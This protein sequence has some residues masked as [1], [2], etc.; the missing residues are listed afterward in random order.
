MTSDVAVPAPATAAAN[1]RG[2]AHTTV[3]FGALT[4]GSIG[5]VYGDIGTSPLYAFREA[6]MAASG[7]EGAPTTVAVLGVVSLILWALVVV[8]TLKYVVIL[9]RADNN[10]EGGTLALMALAQRAVGTGGATIVLLGII[11]GAL[12]YGD[13][14]ITPAVS[15]LSAIEGM[16]DVTLTFEPYIVPLTV[17]ILVVLFAVQSRGTARVAAFFGP[18][19]CVWFA[20]IAIAAIG[21]I[22]RQPQ[23]LLALNP[24]YAVSFMLHHGIIGFVTLG[25][26][27]LAVTGAEALYAD[28]GH[29]G[30]R[31]IQTAWLF[32][33]LPSLALNYLGQGA[34]V[35][36]DPAAI[37]SPFFQ[38]FPQGWVR[39]GM[40]VLA[41]AATV[42]ASQAVITGAYSLTRQA[43]QLG[44]LPRFEIRHTSEA[45]SGQIFIPRIN[46]LLL[47]A[48]IL[49]VLLF[50]SS[51]ALASAYG[52]AVTGTMVVT[53]LMGFVVIWKAWKWSA[54]GAAALIAPFLF[55]DLTFLA[56]NLLKVFEGGWVPLALGSL[57]ILLMYTWRRGSRLL[58]EKSRKLEFPL[59]DLVAMLE[60][61]PPQRVPGTAVFLT[62]DPLSAPT[63]LMHSLKH[64]KVLHEK[65]VILTIETAQT[66]RIDPAERVR[67]EQISPTFSKVRLKFGFMESP[68]VPKALAI[69]RKLGW[70]FDI[71]STS[72]FLSRRAL[73]PAAHS[74]MPRWQ[75][76]LFISLS[77]SANDATDYFQIPSG[78]V[79]EVGTQVTI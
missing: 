74:G 64:Y 47:V 17:L 5:V 34:L 42:I 68:N 77:R 46:Q 10:G 45:H 11:S 27:F 19:M 75:D 26:V 33:V 20:V 40:V 58:F 4:L 79:V 65:N 2:D 41:T 53:G 35:L 9:L 52:I 76:R 63:A 18:V 69:A 78:R 62:S 43:I 30:K 38:L 67:L 23:V 73:K 66:P 29:F 31:P 61:R 37:E 32:V 12:F 1:G 24:F 71:M 57:M 8:V 3:G 14:V 54:L 7:A 59:A 6:V 70:Q 51:S 28:L 13:A 48:V 36:G 49:M 60:K 50:R 25:A 72:F 21:P 15:V 44:L 56:A 16:K 55:L 22:I 39:G